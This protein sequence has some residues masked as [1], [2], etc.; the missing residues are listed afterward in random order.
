MNELVPYQFRE[1]MCVGYPTLNVNISNCSR[2]ITSHP[3]GS[4]HRGHIYIYI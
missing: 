4:H 2:V 1:H 3:P